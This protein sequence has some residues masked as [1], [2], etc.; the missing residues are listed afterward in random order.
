M[1]AR[2][3]ELRRVPLASFDVVPKLEVLSAS[4]QV[5]ERRQTMLDGNDAAATAREL[6]RLLRDEARVIA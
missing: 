2:K 5:K 6:V 4:V 1:K 3:K